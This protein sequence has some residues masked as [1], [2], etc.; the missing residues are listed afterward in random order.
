MFGNLWIFF[1]AFL[2]QLKTLFWF[3]ITFWTTPLILHVAGGGVGSWTHS[4][5]KIPCSHH[6]EHKHSH[7][8]TIAWM[9]SCTC[10][11]ETNVTSHNTISIT[12]EFIYFELGTLAGIHAEAEYITI[13]KDWPEF[14]LPGF[15]S[16]VWLN[17]ASRNTLVQIKGRH[18]FHLNVN[19][20]TDIQYFTQKIRNCVRMCG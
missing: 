9:Q 18:Q 8:L 13:S 19:K 6:G 17:L 1:F 14:C 16:W 12:F 3:N 5:K 20:V 2:L 7:D 15:T 4:T 10:E 11:R